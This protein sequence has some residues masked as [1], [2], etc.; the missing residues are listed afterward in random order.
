MC[1][2]PA[3][4]EYPAICCDQFQEGQGCDVNFDNDLETVMNV[5]DAT[6]CQQ[7]CQ[8]FKNWRY[9]LQFIIFY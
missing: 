8:V 6:T 7:I 3:E 9:K 2:G 1:L 4:P 5:P